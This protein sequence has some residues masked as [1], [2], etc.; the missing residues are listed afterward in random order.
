MI[1]TVNL[2]KEEQGKLYIPSS[3]M[4]MKVSRRVGGRFLCKTSTKYSA[5]PHPTF[6][7]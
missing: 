1:V 6:R 4:R 5:D 7:S 2:V 3:A